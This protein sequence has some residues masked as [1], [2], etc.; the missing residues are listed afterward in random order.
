MSDQ[1][2]RLQLQS[3]PPMASDKF[4]AHMLA[5]LQQRVSCGKAPRRKVHSSEFTNIFVVLPESEVGCAG[6]ESVGC[7][8]CPPKLGKIS[9]MV[10]V[11]YSYIRFS[12]NAQSA[13]DSRRRQLAMAEK[14]A[15]DHHLRLD[16]ALSFRDLGVSAY[17]G[18]N[19][20]EGALR[21][22]LDA[23]EHNLVP[24][25]SYLLIESLD[26]LSRDRILAP[27]A[28]F[29][30][31]IQAGVHIV[32]LADQRCYSLERLNQNPLDLIVSLVSMM[33]ANEESELKSRRVRASFDVR[34]S[35][36]S[37][38]PWS[39]RCPGWLRLDKAAGKFIVVE[40]R[41]E[42]VRGIYRDVLAG[43][44]HQTIARE[45]NER[46]IP[47]FG[48]GNQRGRIWQKS[49]IRHFLRTPTAIGTL[50]P[51]TSEYVDGVRRMRPQQPIEDY[52]PAIID[53]EQWDRVQAKRAAWCAQ[54][55]NNVPKTG[56]ANLLAGLARCP[57][58]DR[59]MML[60]GAGNPNWRYYICRQAYHGVGCSDHWV[61]Y[62]GID[63]ALTVDIDAVITSCPK[64]A[65]TSDARSHMLA[66][67]RGRLNI[68]RARQTSIANERQKVRQSCRPVLEARNAVDAEIE[69]LLADRKRLR[70]DR[71][72]WLD[73][74]LAKRLERL[75]QVAV[76]TPL[77]R[78]E[79]HSIFEALFVKVVIDWETQRLT[80][81]WKHGGTSSVNVAMKPLRE[82]ENR[83]RAD[84]PRYKPGE[85]APA[86][87]V[88]TR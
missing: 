51:F 67:I 68:L 71:P 78:I 28:L 59:R 16:L 26:R 49:L 6:I 73:V 64:P 14:Y 70:I 33:R 2:F 32:T 58:C 50:V 79:L 23:V 25:N 24:P 46:Q 7:E 88:A 57:F 84:R 39:S 9:P 47:L 11:A 40:E 30:Q 10:G 60:I 27:Q 53:R 66:Q 45:L 76:A 81:H 41:A 31:I 4:T 62:P 54:H 1:G 83:R 37:E 44:G 19:A 69:H 29:M 34:R 12:D 72:K 18:R 5:L 38:K 42:I 36:L 15:A 56:R 20:K 35:K 82:V 75:K 80:F 77:N 17:R 21:A 87:P 52:Y 74:T 8:T 61:R 65:L 86:L 63:D 22:F 43:V 55:H 85:T 3:Q 13:G 48:H